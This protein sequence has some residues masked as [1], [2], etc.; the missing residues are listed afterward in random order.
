MAILH[1]RIGRWRKSGRDF[2]VSSKA[3]ELYG[4][5]CHSYNKYVIIKQD[6]VKSSKKQKKDKRCFICNT[7]LHNF[8]C[9]HRI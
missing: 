7:V 8:N 3:T 6:E 5:S 1:A 9:K 2:S 4:I